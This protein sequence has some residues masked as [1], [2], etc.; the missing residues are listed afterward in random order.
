MNRELDRSSC[1]VPSAR[2]R[3]RYIYIFSLN[4]GSPMPLINAFTRRSIATYYACKVKTNIDLTNWLINCKPLFMTQIWVQLHSAN[5]VLSPVYS[6]YYIY[7]EDS[8]FVRACVRARVCV[9][10]ECKCVRL[11]TPPQMLI[12]NRVKYGFWFSNY[13]FFCH[14]WSHTSFWTY[15]FISISLRYTILA[16]SSKNK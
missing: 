16:I 8:G 15:L 13:S 9:H 7:T 14:F 12:N 6:W 1:H 4:P 3:E 10:T 2:E 5:L 11:L